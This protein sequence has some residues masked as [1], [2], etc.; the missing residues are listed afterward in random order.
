MT[1][2]VLKSFYQRFNKVLVTDESNFIK[3]FFS[4]I[5][6]MKI[7]ARC[8]IFAAVCLAVNA[9]EK[10]RYDNY[11][12]YKISIQNQQEVEL[13]VEIENFPDGVS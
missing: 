10:A 2:Q 11:R 6:M 13:F 3:I 4:P 1:I 8:W 5:F 9:F 12:V 7:R